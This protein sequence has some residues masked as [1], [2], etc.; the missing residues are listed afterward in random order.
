MGDNKF[1][2]KKEMVISKAKL[3][4]HTKT[5]MIYQKMI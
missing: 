3:A 1:K 5:L 4:M 2:P